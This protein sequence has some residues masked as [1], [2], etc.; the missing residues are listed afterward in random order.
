VLAPLPGDAGLTG[1]AGLGTL[2]G[3]GGDIGESISTGA[4]GGEAGDI[5][6]SISTGAGGAAGAGGGE[7]GD[8][9]ESIS[10]GTGAGSAGA[11][12]GGIG[13]GAD[14]W[15]GSAG[16]GAGGVT[17]AAEAICAAVVGTTTG[18]ESRGTLAVWSWRITPS[19]IGPPRSGA[20]KAKPPIATPAMVPTVAAIFQ[21]SG[22][23]VVMSDLLCVDGPGG[24]G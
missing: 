9:G 12:T 13:D 1:D 8:T 16:A 5:G 14:S 22:L 18:A 10:T 20:A 4:G 3:L 6:E 24:P 17:V 2:T 21:L 15:T 7:A 19:G 11:T 23:W